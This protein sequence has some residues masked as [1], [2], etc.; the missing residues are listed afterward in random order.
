V[1]RRR[2]LVWTRHRHV[3]HTH[4]TQR[5]PGAVAKGSLPSAGV[6]LSK[7]SI[8]ACQRIGP[9]KICHTLYGFQQP[10]SLCHADGFFWAN[11]DFVAFRLAS[12]TQSFPRLT[13]PSG[14]R[15]EVGNQPTA[16]KWA[17]RRRGILFSKPF[18][19][20]GAVTCVRRRMAVRA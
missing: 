3:T 19:R 4:L 15:A 10:I 1:F 2:A 13:M 14:L 12:D 20:N 6:A 7:V 16:R 11:C 17:S 8:Y 5:R 9:P 18:S